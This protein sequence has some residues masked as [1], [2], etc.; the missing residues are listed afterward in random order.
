MNLEFG[1]AFV[2]NTA[3]LVAQG[4]EDHRHELEQETFFSGSSQKRQEIFDTNRRINE[5]LGQSVTSSPNRAEIIANEMIKQD[6]QREQQKDQKESKNFVAGQTTFPDI[7][8][9]K[10][11]LFD[12]LKT[13]QANVSK[14][15]SISK[16]EGVSKSLP[17]SSQREK[18]FITHIAGVGTVLTQ[19]SQMALMAGG[20]ART[21]KGI[22]NAGSSLM[23]FSSSLQTIQTAKMGLSLGLGYWGVAVSAFSLALSIFC[24]DYDDDDRESE[25]R[26]Q[27]AS[28]LQQ[29]LSTIQQGFQRVESVLIDVVCKKLNAIC[30]KLERLERIM[31]TSFRDLHRK[32]LVDIVD[33]VEKDLNG[34][35]VLHNFERRNLL[36]RLSTWIDCHSNSSIEL[37]Q[38]RVDLENLSV[39]NELVD[40]DCPQ[41]S[42]HILIPLL[43]S[44]VPSFKPQHQMP[45]W[46]LYVFTSKLFS[47]AQQRWKIQDPVD[48]LFDRVVAKFDQVQ[49][50]IALIDVNVHAC[51]HRQYYHQQFMIGRLLAEVKIEFGGEKTLK[52]KIS[53]LCL[54]DRERV[55]RAL[56]RYEVLRRIIIC[57]DTLTKQ[58]GYF[59]FSLISGSTELLASKTFRQDSGGFLGKKIRNRD[60]WVTMQEGY[61]DELEQFLNQGLDVNLHDGWGHLLLRF[62]RS[63]RRNPKFLHR[64]LKCPGIDTNSGSKYNLND[65]WPI[66][67]RP[68]QYILNCSNYPLALLFVANGYNIDSTNY[69]AHWHS[70]C[71]GDMGNLHRWVAENPGKNDCVATLEL[72]MKMQD[73]NS[74]LYRDKL[75]L[76]YQY[77][78]DYESG[79]ETTYTG[80]KEALLCVVCLLGL[81]PHNFALPR[82]MDFDA[83]IVDCGLTWLMLA[84]ASG[85]WNV[86]QFILQTGAKNL[87]VN[88]KNEK[89]SLA[90]SRQVVVPEKSDFSKSLA[91]ERHEFAIVAHA[92]RQNA[93]T[94]RKKATDRRAMWLNLLEPIVQNNIT[95]KEQF[96]NCKDSTGE[97]FL[98][99]LNLL[100]ASLKMMVNGYALGSNID[101]YIQQE[102]KV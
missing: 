27:I 68:I 47:I 7:K 11:Y 79:Q 25:W 58:A 81:I 90:K 82:Q 4:K 62:T 99:N 2:E 46:E 41:N 57:I 89:T 39:F 69:G 54:Q 34:E 31:C 64:L 8:D 53:T 14:S 30:L 72:V 56:Q 102:I 76:A 70:G 26:Q 66:G 63:N 33:A 28:M 67:S 20:H 77:Y 87:V 15:E 44:L 97:E 38:N 12:G 94:T 24:N 3:V 71:W 40:V 10:K 5:S 9:V 60:P 101:I 73:S 88:W 42:L 65:T 19:A 13:S 6:L 85:N 49:K 35:F 51:L 1:I 75:R 37:S 45:N 80:S 55:E 50:T 21:W 95:L 48:A 32:D 86:E 96:Q 100:N 74:F 84:H 36:R 43:S 92:T 91:I 59:G 61:Y 29:I 17:L 98:Q 83:P 22:A 93:Q 52:E 78:K 18:E 16:K 23:T